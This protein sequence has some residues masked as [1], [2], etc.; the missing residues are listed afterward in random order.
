MP[1]AVAVPLRRA[2]RVAA[3]RPCRPNRAV[4]GDAVRA[5]GVRADGQ[6]DQLLNQLTYHRMPIG[7]PLH[8]PFGKD[9]YVADRCWSCGTPESEG[10][11]IVGW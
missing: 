8:N 10:L 4:G 6:L 1:V 9:P 11:P 2:D 7:L 5:V 3:S